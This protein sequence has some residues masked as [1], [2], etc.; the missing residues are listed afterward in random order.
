VSA[1]KGLGDHDQQAVLNAILELR[2]L[3]GE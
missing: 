2:L 3:F 1:Y